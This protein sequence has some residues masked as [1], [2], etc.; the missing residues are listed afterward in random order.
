MRG[1]F[2][3]SLT[4]AALWGMN[5]MWELESFSP[6]ISSFLFVCLFVRDRGYIDRPC[7]REWKKNNK[8]II[9]LPGKGHC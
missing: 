6:Y 3:Q 1:R 9:I 4:H 5:S 7:L 8:R 2:L